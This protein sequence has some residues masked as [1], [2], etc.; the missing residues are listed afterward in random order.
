MDGDDDGEEDVKSADGGRVTQGCSSSATVARGVVDCVSF[1]RK[2]YNGDGGLKDEAVA[3]VDFE[4][5]EEEAMDE[6]EDAVDVEVREA[7]A[8]SKESKMESRVAS[9]ADRGWVEVEVEAEVE[10]DEEEEEE[11]DANADAV[12]V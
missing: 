11:A 4:G 10:L 8:A 2:G 5:A 1:R 3:G 12:A 9:E 7:G 6:A